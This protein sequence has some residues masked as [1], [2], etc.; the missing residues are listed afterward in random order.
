M[1]WDG[2]EG[3]FW[4]REKPTSEWEMAYVNQKGILV[5]LGNDRA[6][7]A[8]IMKGEFRRIDIDPPEN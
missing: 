7:D 5:Y 6:D 8:R 4:Y 2:A 3:Y 1:E